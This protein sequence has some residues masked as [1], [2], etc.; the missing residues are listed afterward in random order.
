MNLEEYN[1]MFQNNFKNVNALKGFEI[2]CGSMVNQVRDLFGRNALLSILF[3]IGAGPGN[4]IAERIK[5]Q[6]KAE[7][8]E[9]LDAFALLMNET[10]DYY[11]IRVR[12]IEEDFDKIRLVFENYC[13][14]RKP[15]RHR[16]DMKF[17]STICRVNKGYFE[18][19]FKKLLGTKIKKIEVNFLYNDKEKGVCVEEIMFYKNNDI[20]KKLETAEEIQFLM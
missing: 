15:I 18:T 13:F 7:E 10:K 11:S 1:F 19:A 3:Q 2:I 8:F 14:L 12:D 5:K 6:Y 9:V 17:G 16:R 4:E 20:P